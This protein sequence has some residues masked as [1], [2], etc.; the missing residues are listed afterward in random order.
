MASSVD[1]VFHPFPPARTREYFSRISF[2]SD[3]KAAII[4]GKSL[5]G[6]KLPI[7]KIYRLVGKLY[8]VATFIVLG[9]R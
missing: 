4:V 7:E 6:S 1:S 3:R 2:G 9:W 5:R 8:L